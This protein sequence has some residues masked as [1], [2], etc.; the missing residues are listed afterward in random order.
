[1]KTFK[2][3]HISDS[4]KEAIGFITANS[5]SEAFKKASVR[6]KLKLEQFKTIFG[7]TENE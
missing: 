4:K 3:F 5:I 6:K 2:Y 7:V 1:M